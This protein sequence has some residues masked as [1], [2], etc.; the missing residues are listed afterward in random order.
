MIHYLCCNECGV[1]FYINTQI[2]YYY[3]GTEA[4][5]EVILGDELLW[6]IKK[7]IWCYACN[8]LTEAE[9][10]LSFKEYESIWAQIKKRKFYD[11][12]YNIYLRWYEPYHDREKN[13]TW[14]DQDFLKYF[15]AMQRR[16]NTR[17]RC[18]GCGG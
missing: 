17:E 5:P 4:M 18:L 8:E 6:P 15:H 16:E 12:D 7:P 11:G 10:L 13:F 2:F 14:M 3:S 9:L 1:K